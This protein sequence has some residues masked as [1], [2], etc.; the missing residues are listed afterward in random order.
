MKCPI[1]NLV[2]KDKEIEVFKFP[3]PPTPHYYIEVKSGLVYETSKM[4]SLLIDFDRKASKYKAM[5]A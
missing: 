4:E 2:F 1:V 5:G 3:N